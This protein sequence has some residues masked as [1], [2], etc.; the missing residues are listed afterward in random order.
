MYVSCDSICI[1]TPYSPTLHIF[2][3]DDEI[4]HPDSNRDSFDQGSDL[5]D[6]RVS[7]ATKDVETIDFSTKDQPRK[8]KIGSPM[9]TDG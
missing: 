8:L 3:I 5:I 1:S 6:E 2:D 7:P 9:Y 4:A